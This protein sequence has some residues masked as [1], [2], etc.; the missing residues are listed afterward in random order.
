VGC[1]NSRSTLGMHRLERLN[2]MPTV[3]DEDFNDGSV[4]E[5]VRFVNPL[6]AGFRIEEWFAG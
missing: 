2:Q 5:G 6:G 3:F 1:E 4:V